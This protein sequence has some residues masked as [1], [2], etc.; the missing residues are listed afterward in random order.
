MLD[1]DRDGVGEG[2]G[3]ARLKICCDGECR[4]ESEV[5]VLRDIISNERNNPA[6]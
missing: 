3:K 2:D 5:E 1:T 6:A 4:L